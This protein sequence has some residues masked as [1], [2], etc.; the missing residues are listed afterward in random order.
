MFLAPRKGPSSSTFAHSEAS[1]ADIRLTRPR[2]S[3]VWLY[4]GVLA[5]LGIALWASAFFVGDATDPDEQPRVGAALDLGAQRTEVLPAVSVPLQTLV[6][7]EM[8]DLG[9]LVRLTG[10][11]ESPVRQNAVWVRTAGGRR[12]LVRFEPPPEP[13]LIAHIRPG[14]SLE[15]DGYLSQISRAE[16]AVWMDTLGVRVPRPPPAPRFGNLPDPDFARVDALFIKNFYVSVR[17]EALQPDAEPA[18]TS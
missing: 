8:R 5:F 12:M 1:M 4:T 13:E 3:R 7:L 15:L 2:G 6:P 16:F 17:P 10:V 18:T 9:R 14:S 11:A